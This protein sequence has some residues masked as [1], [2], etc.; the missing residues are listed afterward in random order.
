MV[1]PAFRSV[2]VG[3]RRIQFRA[4]Q[5][6][7]HR[8]PERFQLITEFAQPLQPIIEVKK[9][10]LALHAFA[11]NPTTQWN[12]KPRQLIRFLE[13][14]SYSSFFKGRDAGKVK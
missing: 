6:K 12:R 2:R 9:S 3:K 10:R 14:S 13:P 7:I 4:K 8:Y 5:L 11:P 1:S